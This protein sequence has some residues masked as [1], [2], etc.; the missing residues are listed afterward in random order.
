M[1]KIKCERIGREN[2]KEDK[3]TRYKIIR[4]NSPGVWELMNVSSWQ[5]AVGSWQLA[6]NTIS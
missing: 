3:T 4:K 6:K 1:I 2:G 5:L